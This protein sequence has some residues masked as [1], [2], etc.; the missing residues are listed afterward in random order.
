MSGVALE[1]KP[2]HFNTTPPNPQSHKQVYQPTSRPLSQLHS[3]IIMNSKQQQ[4][5][6]LH[7]HSQRNNQLHNL[8]NNNVNPQRHSTLSPNHFI[9]S[10]IL[11]S[12]PQLTRSRHSYC[13]AGAHI[14]QPQSPKHFINRPQFPT[15]A[16]LQI[17]NQYNPMAYSAR[18]SYIP[19]SHHV[20]YHQAP[21]S[22]H[23]LHGRPAVEAPNVN[24]IQ[25]SFESPHSS[26]SSTNN[27]IPIPSI[28]NSPRSPLSK[29]ANQDSNH[30]RRSVSHDQPER[31]VTGVLR[32]SL[33]PKQRLDHQPV[34]QVRPQSMTIAE[35]SARH[36]AA[37]SRL[38]Q[39][40]L[41]TKHTPPEPRSSSLSKSVSST[42][43]SPSQSPTASRLMLSPT[44]ETR[45]NKKKL[46]EKD[47]SKRRKSVETDQHPPMSPSQPTSPLNQSHLSP[48][49]KGLRQSDSGKRLTDQV[50]LSKAE[51]RLLDILPPLPPLM[52]KKTKPSEKK[53]VKSE[54]KS[55]FKD[56]FSWFDY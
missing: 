51:R 39:K 17:P 10:P 29:I 15:H 44:N 36:R 27:S 47:L 31:I 16:P 23:S 13:G 45:Q 37:I 18:L 52:N 48:F 40:P 7:Q 24:L 25:T 32:S 19:N 6:T 22:I 8:S 26:P 4:Q 55:R 38:Q 43:T 35:L 9:Q 20:S 41:I 2:D 3:N 11:Q 1:G 14:P 34:S 42:A 46:D 56:R 53:V 21:N 49:V 12:P 30:I 50:E 54:P 33:P 5:P 28:L